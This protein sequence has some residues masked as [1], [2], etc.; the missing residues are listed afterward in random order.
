MDYF[1][2][3]ST[4][5][6]WSSRVGGR[7]MPPCCWEGHMVLST[8]SQG[9]QLMNGPTWQ[10]SWYTWIPDGKL[11]AQGTTLNAER[12]RI[13]GH[14]S[15]GKGLEDRTC[16]V[17]HWNGHGRKEE[18]FAKKLVK[19]EKQVERMGQWWFWGLWSLRTTEWRYPTGRWHCG[20][21]F[22]GEVEDS[23][24]RNL[25]WTKV[26]GHYQQRFM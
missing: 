11:L 16:K 10:F 20:S 23:F 15:M 4:L 9:E 3:Y 12:H 6:W 24:Q 18:G 7:T 1:G 21:A 26:F 17:W 2:T 8:D 25:G 14:G 19:K 13:Q 22:T 5:P